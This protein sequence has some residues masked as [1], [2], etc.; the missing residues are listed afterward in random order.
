[1]GFLDNGAGF[2]EPR[3]RF[4][5]DGGN[6]GINRRNAEIGRIG[7]P[8]RPLAGTRGKKERRRKPGQRQRIGRMLT[9]HGI[10]Q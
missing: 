8:L 7:D 6:L 3:S 10:E 5:G 2:R 9:A 1:M 4:P